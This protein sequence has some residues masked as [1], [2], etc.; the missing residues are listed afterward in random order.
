[1]LVVINVLVLHP[2]NCCTGAPRLSD[3]GVFLYSR[4]A[5]D[6]SCLP[7]CTFI[8]DSLQFAQPF[9]PSHWIGA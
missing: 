2:I 8:G 3:I 6:G 7:E 1:M 9:Q 5:K 4:R